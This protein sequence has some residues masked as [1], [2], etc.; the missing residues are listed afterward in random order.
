LRFYNDKKLTV[1]DKQQSY[2]DDVIDKSV[3]DL[4]INR[5]L[6]KML[7]VKKDQRISF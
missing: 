1:I 4:K 7:K 6:K 5:I 3:T 2:V